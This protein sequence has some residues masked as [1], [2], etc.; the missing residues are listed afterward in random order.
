MVR[1]VSDAVRAESLRK[2]VGERELA[3]KVP[4]NISR[5]SEWTASQR[6]FDKVLT[7][8]S[9]CFGATAVQLEADSLITPGHRSGERELVVN[10]E[11]PKGW[12]TGDKTEEYVARAN[13][14]PCATNTGNC[15]TLS[16]RSCSR[17]KRGDYTTR[18][19][20]GDASTEGRR[21]FRKDSKHRSML[22]GRL[23]ELLF[24]IQ[25]WTLQALIELCRKLE[26]WKR[27]SLLS[28]YQ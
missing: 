4:V 8:H 5:E 11:S 6:T 9:D 25:K 7:M 21:S 26:R 22:L 14:A 13:H 17:R 24:V 3:E 12:L 1:N 18:S 16:G 10:N 2:H 15:G 19:V 20:N 23:L 28:G 27:F